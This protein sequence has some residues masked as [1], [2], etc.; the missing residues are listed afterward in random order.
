MQKPAE[1]HA[2]S[3]PSTSPKAWLEFV[4]C[5]PKPELEEMLRVIDSDCA[6]V[7]ADEC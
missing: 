3:E 4:G 6:T 7:D 2:T 1:P 5:I